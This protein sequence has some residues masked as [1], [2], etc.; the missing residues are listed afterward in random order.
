MSDLSSLFRGIA[1]LIDD[2]VKTEGTEIFLLAEQIESENSH[3]IRL[4]ALPS[5]IQLE[6]LSE[7]SFFVLDWNLHNA[8]DSDELPL[9]KYGDRI[10]KEHI[11]LNLDFLKKIRARKFAPVFIFTNENPEEVRARLKEDDLFNDSPS[12][13]IFVFPKREVIDKGIYFILS[14]WIKGH[15][16]AYVL[17]RWEAAYAETRNSF[18]VD[19]YGFSHL[20]PV[21]LWQNYGDDNVSEAA[22]LTS[23]IGRNIVSR[24]RP[25]P[26]DA[27][28][29]ADQRHID[30]VSEQ[31]KPEEVRKVLEG[32]RF[33]RTDRLQPSVSIG[34]VFYKQGK[35]YVNIRPECDCVAR[36]GVG[37]NDITIYLIKGNKVT[38][39]GFHKL[40]NAQ[41][42]NFLDKETTTTI[43]AMY[44]GITV[45]FQ[46]NDF[47][48]AT[49][50]E[51]KASR[52]GRLVPPFSTKLQQRFAAYIQRVG[53]SRIPPHAVPPDT[54][55]PDA[56]V[57]PA[58]AAEP[59]L[60]ST[61]AV[62]SVVR[63]DGTFWE[64][65]KNLPK[66][67]LQKVFGNA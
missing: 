18:F 45:C 6:N 33:I 44:N 47:R 36:D 42:G 63:S 48:T 41:M 12:D 54:S 25:V 14:E 7:A 67:A 27:A 66:S 24:L 49:W 19:F 15:P 40:Y 53:L 23:M 5:D 61:A 26:F 16:S 51:W 65:L 31:V 34:D 35:Y 46:F 62:A 38:D 59:P 1:V 58:S 30:A 55:A 17:K 43:F 22:E 32:E 10:S 3:V 39:N 9:I 21:V 37:E 64:W 57:E 29:M 28:I 13:H 52:I 50:G 60:S 20:W 56:E 8:N 2:E 11:K 4:P